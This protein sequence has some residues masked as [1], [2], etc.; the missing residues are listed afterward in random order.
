MSATNLEVFG[1]SADGITNAL[2]PSEAGQKSVQ[3]TVQ[4]GFVFGGTAYRAAVPV[5]FKL[6]SK[7]DSGQVILRR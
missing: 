6:S 7:R 2:L 4:V 3:R 1:F 5:T